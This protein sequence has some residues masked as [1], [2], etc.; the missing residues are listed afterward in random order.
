LIWLRFAR[1]RHDDGALD[2]KKVADILLGKN[3]DYAPIKNWNKAG[4]IDRWNKYA[5]G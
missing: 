3:P 1:G 4:V 5:T 2:A